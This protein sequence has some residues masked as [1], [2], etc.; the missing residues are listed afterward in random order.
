[1]TKTSENAP[2][3]ARKRH[4]NGDTYQRPDCGVGICPPR[5][6]LAH[7]SQYCRDEKQFEGTESMF[8]SLPVLVRMIVIV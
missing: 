4:F 1:V 7:F 3:S 8:S 2:K 6:A 5:V